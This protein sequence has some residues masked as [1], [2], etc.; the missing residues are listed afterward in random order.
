VIEQLGLRQVTLIGHS[1][2]GGE[3][4]RYLS[5]SGTGRTSRI[6]LIAPTTPYIL[7]TPDNP[8]GV[9]REVFDQMRAQW[10]KDYPKWLVDNARP[11]FVEDTS[12]ATID[13]VV[14]LMTQPSLKALLDC[15]QA[16]IETDF[17]AEL[18][19]IRV[20]ALIIHGDKD[21]SAPLDV[22]GRK[23]A[24]L[25]PGAQLKVYEGAPHGLM[26]THIDRLN[27]DLVDFAQS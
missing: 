3:V 4:I 26:F 11:F 6:V 10:T 18:P 5:R 16:M 19:K 24:K 21:V 12:Q 22:T 7:Q 20:P 1:M 9:P 23:T 17:R 25:I 27:R 14:R 15:N 8:E 13:W 2:A